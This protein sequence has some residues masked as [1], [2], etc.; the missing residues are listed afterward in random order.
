MYNIIMRTNLKKE[1][2]IFIKEFVISYVYFEEK[3]NHFN[4][5]QSSSPVSLKVI[6][7][8]HSNLRLSVRTG[9]FPKVSE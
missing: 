9:F 7:I 2:D 1:Y 8:L 5:V 3:Y 4:P 6:L